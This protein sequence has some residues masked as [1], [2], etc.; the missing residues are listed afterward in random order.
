[1]QGQ[2]TFTFSGSLYGVTSDANEII[3]ALTGGQVGPDKTT[4]TVF[5]TIVAPIHGEAATSLWGDCSVSVLG[6][7]IQGG[8]IWAALSCPSLAVAIDG[9]CRVE[10]SVITLDHCDGG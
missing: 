6:G 7:Q 10:N 1:V 3:V 5:V 8:S 2:D 4:G 9:S